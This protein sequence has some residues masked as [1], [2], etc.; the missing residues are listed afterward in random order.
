MSN[1]WY[2]VI[3][4]E[5]CTECNACVDFCSHGVFAIKSGRPVVVNPENCVQGCKGCQP[6]CTQGAISHVGDLGN[7]EC[8]CGCSCC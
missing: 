7:Q 4:R 2:P 8:S 6:V 3:D 1:S 5:K